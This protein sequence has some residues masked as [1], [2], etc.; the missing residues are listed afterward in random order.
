MNIL[1][2][3]RFL[4]P[5]ERIAEVLF[6]LIMVLT[7]TGSLS[8]ATAGHAE[9]RTMLLGALGCNIAWGIIDGVFY[10]ME[11]L[12]QKGHTIRTWQAFKNASSAQLAYQVIGN[13]LP[14]LMAKTLTPTEYEMLRLRLL[15]L[16]DPPEYPGLRKNEWFAALMV[17]FWV[18]IIT[19]PVAIPFL[20]MHNVGR[21]MRV[22]NAI[23]ITLL[24]VAGYTFGRCAEY[25]P[26]LTGL[27][28][29]VFGSALV[30]LT[31]ALG[32]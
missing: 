24:F 8:V 13:V 15:R 19:F 17:F 26:W 2:S 27:L 31:I 11:C 23:A 29:V 3:K 9:V 4:T 20:L 18:F 6:G 14:P 22:S 10:L 1:P 30:F 25:K 7:F 21:A 16:S 12:A 28:M 32:G 5:G